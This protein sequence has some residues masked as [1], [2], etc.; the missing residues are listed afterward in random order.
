MKKLKA[1]ALISGGIDSPIAVYLMMKNGVEVVALHLDSQLYSDETPLKQ[2]KESIKILEKKLGKKIKLHVVPHAKIQK[3]IAEKC[4]Y[5]LRC[6][7]CRRMMYRIAEKLAGRES[8]DFIVTG[9]SLGQ[10]ASQTLSNLCV[11]D[12]AVKIPVL[13]PL[14]GFDKEDTIK[15]A[16]DV[17]TFETTAT[18]GGCCALLPNQP[19][20]YAASQRVENEEK[21]LDIGRLINETLKG[22]VK[23]ISE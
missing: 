11:I 20:T 17:G 22:A 21:K 23:N 10:K 18:S 1:I 3:E 5:H 8:A 14:I 9:E 12:S 15:I 19:A 13:R 6:V 16:R 7:I 2:T 4:D